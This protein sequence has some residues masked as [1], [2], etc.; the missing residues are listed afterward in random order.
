M[1]AKDTWPVVKFLIAATGFKRK[2][3]RKLLEEIPE[4]N[5][6]RL[7]VMARAW[8]RD[9]SAKASESLQQ[10][11]GDENL[12]TLLHATKLAQQP[13]TGE[14]EDEPERTRPTIKKKSRQK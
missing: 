9:Q 6:S 14:S 11:V 2:D 12:P 10:L 4:G 5:Y 8:D 13:S 7:F 1:D 3:A